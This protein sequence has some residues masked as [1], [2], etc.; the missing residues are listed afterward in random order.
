MAIFR[1]QN[2]FHVPYEWV[3]EIRS[4]PCLRTN[5][6]YSCFLIM[7][8]SYLISRTS[9]KLALMNAILPAF[10]FAV[11]A[12]TL[13]DNFTYTIFK[14]GIVTSQ[15]ILRAAY[16][17]LFSI[18]LIYLLKTINLQLQ[19]KSKKHIHTRISSYFC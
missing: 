9:K 7:N 2:I 18:F 10:L 13:I 14:F 16:A 3:T 4:I 5:L 19:N 17:L 12:L 15:G 1:H 6:L 8:V 11:L